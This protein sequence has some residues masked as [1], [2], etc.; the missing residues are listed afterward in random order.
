MDDYIKKKKGS[1]SETKWRATLT[2]NTGQIS[3]LGAIKNPFKMKQPSQCYICICMYIVYSIWL[4]ITSR[5]SQCSHSLHLNKTHR[6]G[7]ARKRIFYIW[8]ST[9][10]YYYTASSTTYSGEPKNCVRVIHLIYRDRVSCIHFIQDTT[11]FCVFLDNWPKCCKPFLEY[12]SPEEG[13]RYPSN[14]ERP[15]NV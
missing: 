12:N 8:F 3:K 5:G 11:D 15:W 14:I 9:V 2:S 7:Q 1:S 4:D 13:N 10:Y 6:P